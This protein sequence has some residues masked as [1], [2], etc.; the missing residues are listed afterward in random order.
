VHLVEK[1]GFFGGNEFVNT[2]MER[3]KKIMK[4]WIFALNP[5]RF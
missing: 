3:G 5:L 4:K 1:R 2:Y